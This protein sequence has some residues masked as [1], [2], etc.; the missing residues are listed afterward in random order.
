M[1][2]PL[3]Q[4]TARAAGVHTTDKQ[5]GAVVS[6]TFAHRGFVGV[7]LGQPVHPVKLVEAVDGHDGLV[8]PDVAGAVK[9]APHI[10]LAYPV[11]II[12]GD[13]QAVWM[14]KCAHR[15]IQPR[16]TCRHL[17]SIAADTDQMHLD[18]RVE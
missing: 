3:M 16:E 4:F 9:L 6:H 5:L 15:H 11:G 13:M 7:R 12:G 1:E 2:H 10:G 14:P 17:R 8:P 18:P